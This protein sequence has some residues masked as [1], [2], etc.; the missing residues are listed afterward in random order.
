MQ[1]SKEKGSKKHIVLPIRKI[2]SLKSIVKIMHIHKISI[3]FLHHQI[4]KVFKSKN[5]LIKLEI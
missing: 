2:V 4:N 1:H 3:N 5:K